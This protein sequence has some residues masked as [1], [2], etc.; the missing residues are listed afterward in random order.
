MPAVRSVGVPEHGPH[1]FSERGRTFTK[2]GRCRESAEAWPEFGRVEPNL[3]NFGETSTELG[4]TWPGFDNNSA[5]FGRLRVG[6]GQVHQDWAGSDFSFD[7]CWADFGRSG[8]E[9][10]RF[11]PSLVLHRPKLGSIRPNLTKCGSSSAEGDQHRPGIDPT[12]ADLDSIRTNGP[13]SDKFGPPGAADPKSRNACRALA[14]SGTLRS[15]SPSRNW[16]TFCRSGTKRSTVG[17][18]RAKVE[19]RLDQTRVGSGQS[20]P[21]FDRMLTACRLGIGQR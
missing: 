6:F 4:Q 8:F 18:R 14:N 17:R 2:S 7:R 9:F 10:D 20:R 3:T 5:S 21:G 11:G 16:A 12:R 13:N 15:K 1:E 19:P